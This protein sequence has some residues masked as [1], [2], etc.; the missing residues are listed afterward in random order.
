M[1]N[2]KTLVLLGLV[3]AFCIQDSTAQ[4]VMCKAVAEDASS[5]TGIIGKGI[6]SGILYLMG[7]PYILLATLGFVFFRKRKTSAQ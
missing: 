7:I 6:N 4:C 1:K 5:T 3:L 2:W